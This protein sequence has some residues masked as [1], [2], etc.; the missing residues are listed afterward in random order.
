MMQKVSV[1]AKFIDENDQLCV[2][3]FDNMEAAY[4][5]LEK[6]R[7]AYG[8]ESFPVSMTVSPCFDTE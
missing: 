6:I 4:A 3:Y 5:R 1:K 2:E 7:L 8:G